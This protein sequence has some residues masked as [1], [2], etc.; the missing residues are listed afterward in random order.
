MIKNVPA[1]EKMDRILEVIASMDNGVSFNEIVCKTDFNKSTVYAILVTLENLKYVYKS[2]DRLYFIDSKLLLLG[3]K[4]SEFSKL[5]RIFQYEANE[6]LKLV[7]ETCQLGVIQGYDLCYLSKVE[8]TANILIKTEPGQRLPAYATAMGKILL[9]SYAIDDLK[10]MFHSNF[11]QQLTPNTVNSVEQL[12][13]QIQFFKEYGY[14]IERGETVE[15]VFCIAAPITNEQGEI[16]AAISFS[17]LDLHF[18]LKIN[19]LAESVIN[20]AKK[21]SAQI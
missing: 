14:A 6:N 19:D 16:I 13:D 11:Y 21:I 10:K 4:F 5:R 3:N 17:V 15:G 1:I 9:S 7:N 20:L 2:T 18:E 12:L 8:S